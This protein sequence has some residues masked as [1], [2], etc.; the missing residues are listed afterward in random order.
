MPCPSR[1]TA[2][3]YRAR[4]VE[5]SRKAG[6]RISFLEVSFFHQ[7]RHLQGD[8]PG[9]LFETLDLKLSR[10]SA[11]LDFCFPRSQFPHPH[12]TTTCRRRRRLIALVRRLL[13]PC[14]TNF[15]EVRSVCPPPHLHLLLHLLLWIH[16]RA[17]FIY[18]RLRFSLVKVVMMQR[19]VVPQDNNYP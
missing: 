15:N 19:V 2:S 3:K 7:K 16:T 11:K 18:S 4:G 13:C 6:Y 12:T 9:S 5:W 14:L 1:K 17:G 8:P 10:E